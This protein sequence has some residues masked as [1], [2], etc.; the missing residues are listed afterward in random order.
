MNT[1]TGVL[2][3]AYGSP[4]TPDQVEPYFR[5]IRGGRAPSPEAVEH[6]RHRYELIGGRTPL[7]AIT[8][9]TARGLQAALDHRAPGEYRT[10]VAMKHWHPYIADVIPRLAADGIRRVIAIVLAPHYSRMSVGGYRQYVEQTIASL[11]APMELTF[12]ETWHMQPEF[13]ELMSARVR[14]GLTQFPRGED[15][16]VLFSAHSLP[17]RIRTWDDPYEA[18]LNASCVAVARHAQLRDWRFAWQSAG[19]TGEP[20]L[21]PDIVDYLHVLHSEGVRNVLSVPIGFVCEH[22]EVLYDIDHE[23]AQKAA[24]LGMTLRRT[25]MPNATPEFIDVLDALVAEAEQT[26]ARTELTAAP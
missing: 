16:C 20:W 26:A 11:D 6:L 23:A 10:Y 21:G 3:L 12:V 14:E 19:G 8:T 9:D 24:A 13:L 4:E 2:L 7:L 5:H 15:V 25:R 1:P 17:V 18:Q 22:L